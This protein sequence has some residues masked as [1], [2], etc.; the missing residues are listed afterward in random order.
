MVI[1]NI[2]KSTFGVD[3]LSFLAV[4]TLHRLQL[5]HS[6]LNNICGRWRVGDTSQLIRTTRMRLPS[7]AG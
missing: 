5:G 1:K 6:T 2:E 7:C 3:V 4:V